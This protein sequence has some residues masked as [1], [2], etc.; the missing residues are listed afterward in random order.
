MSRRIAANKHPKVKKNNKTGGGG[1]KKKGSGGGSKGSGGSEGIC[2]F[3]PT[4]PTSSLG[5]GG[6][7]FRA[8]YCYSESTCEADRCTSCGVAEEQREDY[9]CVPPQTA[10]SI[11]GNLDFSPN[12]NIAK[13]TECCQGKVSSVVFEVTEPGIHKYSLPEANADAYFVDCSALSDLLNKGEARTTTISKSKNLEKGEKLCVA[14][15]T[16]IVNGTADINIDVCESGP[17]NGLKAV[18]DSNDVLIFSDAF[19]EGSATFHVSCS[20]SVNPGTCMVG[21]SGGT[22]GEQIPPPEGTR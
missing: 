8:D 14:P 17:S 22:K 15:V 2:L 13:C 20:Q 16:N 11:F 9:Y 18:F 4:N 10:G 21:G 5:G 1:S 7:S 12:K 19:P 3:D 6:F